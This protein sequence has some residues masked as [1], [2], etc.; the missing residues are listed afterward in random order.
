MQVAFLLEAH[1]LHA[2]PALRAA[3]G[4]AVH[5][6]ELA[7]GPARHCLAALQVGQTTLGGV[8]GRSP[9]WCMCPRAARRSLSLRARVCVNL[10]VCV[11]VGVLVCVFGWAVRAG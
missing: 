6:L 7:A 4:H 11:C 8:R 3:N 5:V 9:A 10:R 2:G 1:R